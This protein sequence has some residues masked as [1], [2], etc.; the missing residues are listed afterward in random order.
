MEA[1]I[2]FWLVTQTFPPP[3]PVK[4]KGGGGGIYRVS[5]AGEN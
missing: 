4:K 2:N 5:G 1:N 3:V